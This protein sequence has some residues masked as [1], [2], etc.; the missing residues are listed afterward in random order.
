MVK[1][2]DEYTYPLIFEHIG[3]ELMQ[4]AEHWHAAFTAEM[5]GNGHVWY[6]EARGAVFRF[7]GPEGIRQ[8]DIQDRL[9]IS[10]QAVQ[11]LLDQLE[12]EGVVM[13]VVDATDARSKRVFLGKQGFAAKQVANRAKIKIENS[14]RKKLGSKKFEELAALLGQLNEKFKQKHRM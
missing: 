4:A 8:S 11:Q 5:V 3:W 6:G 1:Q 10:K 14:I 12:T 13:R 7:I 9:N 2:I